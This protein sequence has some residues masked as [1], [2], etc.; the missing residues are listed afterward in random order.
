MLAL[1][2]RRPSVG[3][4]RSQPV[5][6]RRRTLAA[7]LFVPIGFWGTLVGAGFLNLGALVL[8]LALRKTFLETAGILTLVGPERRGRA[9]GSRARPRP[10][11]PLGDP[12]PLRGDCEG[13]WVGIHSSAGGPEARAPHRLRHVFM[14]EAPLRGVE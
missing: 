8:L 2:W 10:T 6:A 3:V 9:R 14:Y 7:L 13:E 11:A 5:G 4:A 1:L 12:R